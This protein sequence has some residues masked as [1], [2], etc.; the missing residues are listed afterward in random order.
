MINDFYKIIFLSFPFDFVSFFPLFPEEKAEIRPK[1]VLLT[2]DP[3]FLIVSPDKI[4]AINF[5]WNKT[6]SHR[7]RVLA[8]MA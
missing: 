1:N 3:R 5:F 8:V 2:F 4:T 6:H 7:S